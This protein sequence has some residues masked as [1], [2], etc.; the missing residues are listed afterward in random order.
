VQVWVLVRVHQSVSVWVGQ[1]GLASV[2][3]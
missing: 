3:V 1:W 2:Q